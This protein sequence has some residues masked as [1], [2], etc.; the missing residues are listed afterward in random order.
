M[1]FQNLSL[2][3]IRKIFL[4]FRKFQ[5]SVDTPIEYIVIEKRQLGSL[6]KEFM[7]DITT[8]IF[9]LICTWTMKD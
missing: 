8:R 5:P 1:L 7:S 4:E 3:F 6:R 9:P 2:G